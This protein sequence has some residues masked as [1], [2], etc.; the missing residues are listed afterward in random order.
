MHTTANRIVYINRSGDISKYDISDDDTE[1]V[2]IEERTAESM[3]WDLRN[4]VP[5]EKATEEQVNHVFQ[6]AQIFEISRPVINNLSAMMGIYNIKN[7]LTNEGYSLLIAEMQNYVAAR[8]SYV[9]AR[10]SDE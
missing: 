6:I 3:L 10:N 7:E 2:K 5:G 4:G 9:G 1:V 8:N